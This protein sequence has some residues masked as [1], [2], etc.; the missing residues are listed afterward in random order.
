MF[1]LIN[2]QLLIIPVSFH[3]PATP[4]FHCP[5]T[6]TSASLS[7]PGRHCICL[8]RR[9][10]NTLLQETAGRPCLP[11]VVLRCGLAKHFCIFSFINP[12]VQLLLYQ[13]TCTA[14]LISTHLY[15][16]SC[17][18]TLGG[19]LARPCLVGACVP[20]RPLTCP[21]RAYPFA[22]PTQSPPTP[23]T[24]V[25]EHEVAQLALLVRTQ[26]FALP[27]CP[28]NCGG[29]RLHGRGLCVTS[30]TLNRVTS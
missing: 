15:T 9:H 20:R 24:R 30:G 18:L 29:H 22:L 11:C 13:P 2:N 27:T 25:V 17:L 1:E 26:K 23:L 8:S 6:P 14:S 4:S 12:L 10:C 19:L 3:C 16:F 21:T 7:S 28:R 5:A